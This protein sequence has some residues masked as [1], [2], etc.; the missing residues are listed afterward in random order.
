MQGSVRQTLPNTSLNVGDI[1]NKPDNMLYN[2]YI[3]SSH[4]AHID[5]WQWS[6]ALFVQ[7]SAKDS[8][9]HLN[10][11]WQHCRSWCS[12]RITFRYHNLYQDSIV[13]YKDDDVVEF[14][15]LI[16]DTCTIYRK[17]Q[18]KGNKWIF[19]IYEDVHFP[20]YHD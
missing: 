13:I 19:Q 11:R 8:S 7:R 17:G 18:R 12:V 4:N 14:Y 2:N 20:I 6:I 10:R 16:T 3:T 5:A 15:L 1:L 9:K